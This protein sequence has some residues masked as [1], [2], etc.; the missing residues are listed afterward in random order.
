MDW[1]LARADR[2]EWLY[3]RRRPG[4]ARRIRSS[5]GS[6]HRHRLGPLARALRVANIAAIARALR[7]LAVA[8]EPSA[9]KP[10]P[11]PNSNCHP[12]A[13]GG[14]SR[15]SYPGR[16]RPLH[17]PGRAG[18]ANRGVNDGLPVP[19]SAGITTALP[20]RCHRATARAP[21]S[22]TFPSGDNIQG[23]R[24]DHRIRNRTGV[25]W[26]VGHDLVFARGRA[27]PLLPLCER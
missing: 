27:R 21:A 26:L 17:Q 1:A 14:A 22:E 9:Q 13:N 7:F 2:A 6:R 8:V 12:R 19:Q 24:A 25:S 11:R 23:A 5:A 20:P 18:V 15:P 4:P 3:H 10:S 16:R